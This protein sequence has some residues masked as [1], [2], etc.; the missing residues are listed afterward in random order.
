MLMLMKQA[1]FSSV[2]M[3]YMVWLLGGFSSLVS[4]LSYFNQY[5][6]FFVVLFFVVDI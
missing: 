5:R 3:A 4:I 6:Y 1:G 2:Y